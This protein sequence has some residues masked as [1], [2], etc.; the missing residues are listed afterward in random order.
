MP[1]GG[2][3]SVLPIYE[4]NIGL[5]TVLDI[6]E[7]DGGLDLVLVENKCDIELTLL[8]RVCTWSLRC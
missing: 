2:L 1:D 3:V 7:T 8:P 6:Y 5:E 4:H